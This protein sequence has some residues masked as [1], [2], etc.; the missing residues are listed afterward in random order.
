MRYILIAIIAGALVITGAPA[1]A[2]SGIAINATTIIVGG[3]GGGTLPINPGGSHPNSMPDWASIFPS[4]MPT[5]Q[6]YGSSYIPVQQPIDIPPPVVG[7][8]LQTLSNT[9]AIPEEESSPVTRFDWIV[10]LIIIGAAC[11]IGLVIWIISS[12]IDK[13]RAEA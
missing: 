8:P 9:A 3:T 11:V 2:D 10:L 6:Q 5:T 12:T 7:N 13:N 4:G 1:L